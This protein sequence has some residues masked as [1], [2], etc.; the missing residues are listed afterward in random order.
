MAMISA[1][2]KMQRGDDW[3]DIDKSERMTKSAGRRHREAA[4]AKSRAF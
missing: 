1:V 3:R 4:I 2:A